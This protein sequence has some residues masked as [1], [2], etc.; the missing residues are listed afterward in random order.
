MITFFYKDINKK[1]ILKE[2]IKEKNR[3]IITN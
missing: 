3:L 2:E 1:V